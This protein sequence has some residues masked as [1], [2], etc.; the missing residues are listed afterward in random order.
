MAGPVT[1]T[2]TPTPVDDP[3]PQREEE[4]ASVSS[5]AGASWSRLGEDAVPLRPTDQRDG[6]QEERLQVILGSRRRRF[7]SVRLG[8]QAGLAL[9]VLALAA[10][11]AGIAVG[12]GGGTDGP[13]FAVDRSDEGRFDSGSGDVIQKALVKGAHP[14]KKSNMSR[15]MTTA[16][17]Q[18]ARQPRRASADHERPPDHDGTER[19]RRSPAPEADRDSTTATPEALPI[20]TA[21]PPTDSADSEPPPPPQPNQ[22][23]APPA[24]VN[25]AER[26]FGFER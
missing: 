21:P 12:S 7:P 25:Q 9:S 17:R 1:E 26:E 11:A 24:P 3:S 23:S 4:S 19:E 22:S 13:A 16:P 20:Y 2:G 14:G 15:P 18:K 10:I 8:A 6:G 5:G